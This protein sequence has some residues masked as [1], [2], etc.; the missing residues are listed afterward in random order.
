MKF[1]N[2]EFV[3]GVACAMAFFIREYDQPSMALDMA[4]QFGYTLLD[5]ESAEVDLYDL[6]VIRKAYS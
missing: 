4:K 6:E 5:F 1:R 2:K 3:Q